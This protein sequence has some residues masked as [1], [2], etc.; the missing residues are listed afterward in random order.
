VKDYDFAMADD[1]LAQQI[2]FLIQA[3]RLK[4][5]LRR[6]PLTD[7]SRLENSAEHSWHLALAA[8]ALSEHAPSGVDI[9]RTLQLVVIHDLVEIDAGDT[10]AYDPDTHAHLT[11]ADRERAA[12]ERLFGL[13]P[14]DQRRLFRALWDEFEA[15][16]TPEARFANALDRF[17]ALLLNSQSGGG[18]WATHGVMRSQVLTRMAPVQSALPSL[19]PF[20]L[21]VIERACTAGAI[22]PD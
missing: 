15:H 5:I 20:V 14:S 6:T 10:F 3:D 4:T 17:Q 19:W 7:N 21:D 22:V 11:K 1:R 18:S 13:L 2:A 12:A 16:A 9:G 8:L